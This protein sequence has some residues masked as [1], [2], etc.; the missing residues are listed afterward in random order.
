LLRYIG[1]CAATKWRASACAIGPEPTNPTVLNTVMPPF[2][3]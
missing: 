1:I 2:E 3:Q